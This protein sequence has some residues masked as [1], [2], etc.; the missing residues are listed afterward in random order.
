[1]TAEELRL[2]SIAFHF[3]MATHRLAAIVPRDTLD[4]ILWPVNDVIEAARICARPVRRVG[5][6]EFKKKAGTR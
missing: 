2:T 5:P 3:R 4:G 6:K 1:M